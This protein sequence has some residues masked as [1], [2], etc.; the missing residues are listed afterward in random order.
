MS[1]YTTRYGGTKGKHDE[2]VGD[3]TE[4]HIAEVR[5]EE[6]SEVNE[7]DKV[8]DLLNHHDADDIRDMVLDNE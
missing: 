6:K 8:V 4:D 3:F 1:E 7:V 2:D 5:V